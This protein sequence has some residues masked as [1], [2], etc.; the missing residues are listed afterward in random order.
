[1]FKDAL[2]PLTAIVYMKIEFNIL[3]EILF[4]RYNSE[5]YHTRSIMTISSFIFMNTG[6]L[7]SENLQ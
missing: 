4:F 3:S 7:F 5:N 6:D 2:F 1:M